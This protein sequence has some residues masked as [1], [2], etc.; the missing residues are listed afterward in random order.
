MTSISHSLNHADEDEPVGATIQFCEDCNNMLAPFSEDNMLIYKCQ[1][2]T[3]DF[4]KAVVGRGKFE[5]LV[6]RKE[7]L[8]E[9]NLIIDPDYSIDPTMPREYVLCPECA[10]QEAVFLIS[11]DIEDTKIEL[12]YICGNTECGHSWKKQV[13]E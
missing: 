10:F 8:K 9:K 1:K 5:N 7:F 3:C 4:R 12:I 6:S 11:T 13:H 2:P